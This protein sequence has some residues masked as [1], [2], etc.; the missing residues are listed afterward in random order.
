MYVNMINGDTCGIGRVKKRTLQEEEA[1]GT[2]SPLSS[3]SFFV[4]FVFF[5]FF[6]ISIIIFLIF[7][8]FL[9]PKVNSIYNHEYIYQITWTL[10]NKMRHSSPLLGT[11]FK[12]PILSILCEV[13]L[14]TF[15]MREPAIRIVIVS[16]YIYFIQ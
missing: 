6:E 1:I 10:I 2:C 8:M 3:I 12:S 11:Q 4:F 14:F 5:L 16:D 13:G 7:S 15:E 9:A